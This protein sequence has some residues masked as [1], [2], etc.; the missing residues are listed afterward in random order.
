MRGAV[1]VT[2]EIYGATEVLIRQVEAS[3]HT[4]GFTKVTYSDREMFLGSGVAAFERLNTL[5]SRVLSPE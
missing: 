1:N 4:V 3:E 2:F 5:A